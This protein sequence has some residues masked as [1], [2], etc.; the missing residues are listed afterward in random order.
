[1]RAVFVSKPNTLSPQQ[2]CFWQSFKAILIRHSLQPRTVGETDDSDNA[3]LDSVRRLLL[4]C[5]GAIILGLRQAAIRELIIRE[6]TEKEAVL[7]AGYLPT[8]WNHIEAGMALAL[9]IPLFVLQ[10]RE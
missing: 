6:G 9:R 3:V 8:P 2:C 7:R 5:D 4:Q 1:M 10:R